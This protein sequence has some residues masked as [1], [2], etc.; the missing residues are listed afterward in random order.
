MRTVL[1]L[2]LNLLLLTTE[3]TEATEE[4]EEKP[5]AAD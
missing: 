3:G 4:R 1:N 2:K 5:L